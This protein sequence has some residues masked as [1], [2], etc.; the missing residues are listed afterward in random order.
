MPWMETCPMDE[1]KKFVEAVIAEQADMDTVCGAFGISRKTGYKWLARFKVGGFAALV[2]QSRAPLT[3]PNATGAELAGEILRARA[4]H[5]LWG[6]KKLKRHLEVKTGNLH[7]PAASTIG[8]LLKRSGLIRERRRRRNMGAQPYAGQLTQGLEPNDVWF[9]DF[10]G[11]FR[12]GSGTRVDPLTLSDGASRFLIRCRAVSSTDGAMVKKQYS[13]AFHEFGLPLAIRTDNGAPFAGPGLCGLSRLAVWLLKLG[14]RPER[15]RP[16]HPQD[17]GVHE[18]MHRTLKDHTA[19]PPR[20]T[21]RE[22]QR[23][24]DEFRREFNEERP[25]EGLEMKTPR[26]VY[27]SSPRPM[28]RKLYPFDYDGM[29]VRKVCANGTISWA[30]QFV[31]ISQALEGEKV[32]VSELGEGLWSVHLGKLRLGHF[33]ERDGAI[34]TLRA[35]MVSPMSP[36]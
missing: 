5:P 1:R 12:T 26:E 25:H 31:Y 24:F 8:D 10:K 17:N 21:M 19:S 3:H 32:G 29:A 27:R 14:I 13:A 11:W 9:A 35:E 7:W 2:D 34:T 20:Q 28:P 22:Q 36:V 4:R 23:A 33:D 18:R 16:G 30:R 6:P 15:I